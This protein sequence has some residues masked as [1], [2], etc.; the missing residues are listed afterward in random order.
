MAYTPLQL[1]NTFIS[2]YGKEAGIDHMKLQK[3][4]YYAYGW[5]IAYQPEPLLNESPQVWEYGPVFYSLFKVLTGS[6]N[7]PIHEPQKALPFDETPPVISKN[8]KVFNFLDWV[9]NQY[10]LFTG[11]EL[12]AQT[13]A[14]GTPWKQIAVSHNFKVPSHYPIPDKLMKE[15]FLKEGEKLKPALAHA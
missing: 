8:Q 2:R 9:W 6:R 5:W 7:L 14:D 12:S 4:A 15:F 1:A 13:H 10:G 3:L 11:M